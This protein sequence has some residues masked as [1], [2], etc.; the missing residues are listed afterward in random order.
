MKELRSLHFHVR[1]I[2]DIN[3]A[4]ISH[5]TALRF[6]ACTLWMLHFLQIEGNTPL[7]HHHHQQ[8]DYNSLY[9]DTCFIA[10]VW[11]Q[12]HHISE[13]C[14]PYPHRSLHKL[15]PYLPIILT[16]KL[17]KEKCPFPLTTLWT[18]DGP[19][20]GFSQPPQR[21]VKGWITEG[22][23]GG[24]RYSLS[25]CWWWFHGCTAHAC[26]NSSIIC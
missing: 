12:T 16:A 10:V 15:L 23:E 11:N 18:Q 6:P 3:N 20:L 24:T 14:M 4:H 8:K 1:I 25:W 9:F 19:H 26:Q 2:S 17:L 7:H 22:R 13:V 21:K 5:F